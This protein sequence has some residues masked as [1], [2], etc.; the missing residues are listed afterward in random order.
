MKILFITDLLPYPPIS[1]DRIRVYNIIR[2]LARQHRVWLFSMFSPEGT[3]GVTHMEEFCERV[4]AIDIPRQNP[5]FHLPGLMRFAFTGRPLGLKFFE[6]EIQKNKI[7]ELTKEEQF[8]IVNIE[9]S[10]MALYRESLTPNLHTKQVLGFHNIAF[11]QYERLYHFE[12]TTIRKFRAW[13]HKVEMR[14]WEAS[15]AKHFDR[16][17]VV[18]EIERDLL[19]ASNPHLVVNV[20]PNGVDTK[21]YR[22]LSA[23]DRSAPDILF[24]GSMDCVPVQ[25]A[26][27]YFTKEIL[28]RIQVE[29]SEIELWLVGK[30]PS[31]DLMQLNSAH[32]H[33][34]GRVDDILPYYQRCAVCVVPLRAGGGT[35]LKILEAMALGRPVVSTTIGCE[36]LEVVDGEHLLIADTPEQFSEKTVRLLRDRQLYQYISSNGR[37][38]VEVHYGWD[39][40][41]DQLMGVYVEMVAEP[42]LPKP[43]AKG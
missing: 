13:L 25:D 14:H 39:K 21:I 41:A 8:D 36:G 1:G 18:S 2:R 20:I 4:E 15:Y 32:V 43:M 31:P 10:H 35:R 33:V 11:L 17:T 29:I 42:D 38:L 16:C 24:I 40:I 37:R 12:T 7:R 23:P 6:S 34:T 3:T 19:L 22:P 26:A 30:N 28:P 9:P 5:V 27:Y